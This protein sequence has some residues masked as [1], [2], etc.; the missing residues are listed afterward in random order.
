MTFFLF[1][2]ALNIVLSSQWVND[3]EIG[4]FSAVQLEKEQHTHPPHPVFCNNAPVLPT[5]IN[6]WLEE[7]MKCAVLNGLS[8]RPPSVQCSMIQKWPTGLGETS[9]THTQPF[10]SK[11]LFWC[12]RTGVEA[13]IH[14][15]QHI[16]HDRTIDISLG[17]YAVSVAVRR[18]SEYTNEILV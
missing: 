10:A 2:K 8:D 9:S 4:I 12:L 3:V 6:G 14:L 7:K 13:D 1:I 11:Y 17:L 15:M 18:A 5:F 16:T